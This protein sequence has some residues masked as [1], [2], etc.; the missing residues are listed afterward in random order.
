M[1]KKRSIYRI[2][3]HN[4]GKI[5]E[6]YARKVA[7]GDMYGFVEVGDIIFGEKSAVLV[8]PSEE[9]LKS[10]FSGVKTTFVP[11][12][13]IVR[14]DEVEKEGTNKVLSADDAGTNVAQFPMPP[15]YTPNGG[16]DSPS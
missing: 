3:F 6:L 5:Y 15:V 2:V 9:R 7:Q 13:A 12:H 8:D 11:M 14:I 1:A 16:G 4:Q 10:E